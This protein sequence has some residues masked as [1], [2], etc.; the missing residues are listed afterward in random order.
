MK[1]TRIVCTMGPTTDDEAVIAE[2]IASGMNVARFNFSHGTHEE[3]KQRMDMVK[4]VR[5]RLD[6][7]IA[8]ML[9]TKG[10][11][12]RVRQFEHG[13]V[14]LVPNA[15]FI[16]SGAERVGNESGVA[17]TYAD[18]AAE[19]SVGDVVLIDDGLIKLIVE[20]I[21]GVDVICRVENGGELKNN[22]SIN[23]PGVHI[24]FPRLNERD[25]SDIVFGIEQDIDCIAASFVR[26]ADDIAAIKELL[27]EHNA[28]HIMVIA[29]IENRQGV[30]NLDEIISA[31]D[32][33]MVARGDLGV[34]I[35]PQEVPLVQKRMIHQC[36]SQGKPVITATQML[37]SMIRNP[38]PTRAEAADVAN[39]VFDGTDAVMLSGETASGKYPALSVR[40]MSSIVEAAESAPQ[41]MHRAEYSANAAPSVTDTIGYAS[42]LSSRELK[43]K[44]ILTPT[45]SGYTA[46][47]VAK[48]RPDA[49]VVAL[50]YDARVIRSLML[51]Y[52]VVA[53]RIERTDDYEQ[54]ISASLAAAKAHCA[55]PDGSRVVI[56]AG[57]PINVSGTTNSIRIE[58]V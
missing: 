32:G 34:E 48:Y 15:R 25:I 14:E 50:A 5:E 18:L 29:K 11:E 37:D 58:Y 28:P 56:T 27:R 23:L 1:K 44:A 33:I 22:K 4:H 21:A 2:M 54:L 43:A 49:L 41:Y 42:V 35:P 12:I 38:R 47:A 46:R 3:Q 20:E 13:A 26:S 45:T 8:L 39:A 6:V 55:L 10:P 36:I 19:L 24:A 57:L 17:V 53:L 30:D 40:T 31:A 9:D 7:P 51:T 52:G 16:L